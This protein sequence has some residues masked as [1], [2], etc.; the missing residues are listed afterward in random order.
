MKIRCCELLTSSPALLWTALWGPLGCVPEWA[1]GQP[2]LGNIRVTT[3][4]ECAQT[5]AEASGTHL[6]RPPATCPSLGR[7]LGSG[8]LRSLVLVTGH[9]GSASVCRVLPGAARLLVEVSRTRSSHGAPTSRRPAHSPPWP[10]RPLDSWPVASQLLLVSVVCASSEHVSFCM[11]TPVT[12][13]ALQGP[14]PRTVPISPCGHAQA[15]S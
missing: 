6:S 11:F 1:R 3:R 10:L 13:G 15:S 2:F 5:R 12:K 9:T 4:K 8:C 7:R 14:G